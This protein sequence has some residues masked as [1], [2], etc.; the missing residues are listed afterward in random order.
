MAVR[1]GV[2]VVLVLILL[3]VARLGRRAAVPG[4]CGGGARTADL[5]QLDAAPRGERRPAGNR[6]RR[7]PRRSSSSR[8]A[9]RAVD[10]RRA[11]QGGRRPARVERHHPADR[12]RRALGQGAGGSRRHHRVQE[13]E[14]ADRRLP[15]VR[16]RPVVLPGE[17]LRQGVPHADGVARPHRHGELRALPARRVS[18]RSARFR[19]RCTSATTRR[20]RTRSPSTRSPRRTARWP[21]RSI[22]ICYEQLVAGL[23]EGRH[24]TP[25]EIR[26]LIDHGPFLPEDA[27]RAGLIDDLAY[28]DEIDDKV[29]LGRGP[30]NTL[31][32]QEYRTV[33]LELAR[34]QPRAADRAHLRHRRHQL[35][36]EHRLAI[37]AGARLRHDDRVPAQGARRQLD[38][39]HRAAES[40]APAGRLS[41]PT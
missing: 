32:Q 34:T 18:T 15:R 8:A 23:A 21:S 9:D 39:R 33:S 2:V 24:R 35:R 6:P 5:V 29:D 11:A 41:P 36:G 38:S 4:P 12:H 10:R 25:D 7:R 16:G 26:A 27:V 3:A 40:T 14:E 22:P 30:T 20:R 19:M 17:R 31:R 37:G 1:R 28:E 13:V